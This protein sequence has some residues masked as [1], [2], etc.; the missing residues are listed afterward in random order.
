M[1]IQKR[2]LGGA[3]HLGPGVAHGVGEGPD[4]PRDRPGAKFSA[5]LGNVACQGA[6]S[7]D[8]AWAQTGST[9]GGRGAKAEPAHAAHSGSNQIQGPR[10]GPRP[11]GVD[12]VSRCARTSTAGS[13]HVRRS[14]GHLPRGLRSPQEARSCG[15]GSFPNSIGE[16]RRRIKER[17]PCTLMVNGGRH[18]GVV[19][20]L[21]AQG[22]FVETHAALP[23][24]LCCRGRLSNHRGRAVRPR[25]LRAEP[26]THLAQP[27]AAGH[28][29]CRSPP[30]G[31]PGSLSALARRRERERV[32]KARITP[33]GPGEELIDVEIFHALYSKIAA[34]G[35]ANLRG[36]PSS[37]PG[38][39]QGLPRKSGD[40]SRRDSHGSPSDTPDPREVAPFGAYA[41]SVGRDGGSAEA[42]IDR[43]THRDHVARLAVHLARAY[44]S[45]AGLLRVHR[46]VIHGVCGEGVANCGEQL[47]FPSD[48]TSP[49]ADV[50]ASHKPRARAPASGRTRRAHPRDAGA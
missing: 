18:P 23:A 28:R 50:V 34:E 45:A 38:R 3:R 46:G 48:V 15:G 17:I 14:S 25:G 7:G 24:W 31:A 27:E 35:H 2:S 29:R 40:P 6:G 21:S 39:A 47:L 11:L 33:L 10:S 32:M 36:A 22:L 4:A 26:A 8:A 30:R 20:N 1:S 43:S 44:V 9:G 16:K 13:R 12:Q 41:A 42:E 5:S 19:Q 49:F 37:P